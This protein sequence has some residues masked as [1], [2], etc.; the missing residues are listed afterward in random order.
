MKNI[1]GSENDSIEINLRN[2]YIL[3]IQ[4]KTHLKQFERIQIENLLVSIDGIDQKNINQYRESIESRLHRIKSLLIDFYLIIF[5]SEIRTK[6]ST[7]DYRSDENSINK[8]IQYVVGLCYKLYDVKIAFSDLFKY[9]E[10]LYDHILNSELEFSQMIKVLDDIV[11]NI[12]L[13]HFNINSLEI[14]RDN[15][16]QTL[17]CLENY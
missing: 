8:R 16:N 11:D 14:N 10:K 12:I 15:I 5:S 7:K 9:F 6:T 4:L 17:S 1:I 3:E 2:L 13:E